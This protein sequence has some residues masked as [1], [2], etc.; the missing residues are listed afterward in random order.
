MSR[1]SESAGFNK[2]YNWLRMGMVIWFAFSAFYIR[3]TFEAFEYAV[4]LEHL[5]CVDGIIMFEI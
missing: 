4:K 1:S 2:S 5:G 3:C